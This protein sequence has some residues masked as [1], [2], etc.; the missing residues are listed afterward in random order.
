M[1]LGSLSKLIRHTTVLYSS[2]VLQCQKACMLK[3]TIVRPYRAC[4]FE[5]TG[6]TGAPVHWSTVVRPCFLSDPFPF[7]FI[8]SPTLS[9][10]PFSPLSPRRRMS[11]L[12]PTSDRH[13]H[14]RSSHFSLPS[15]FFVSVTLSHSASPTTSAFH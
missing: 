7:P 11:Q 9:K 4:N 1:L 5:K 12:P 14:R 13:G 3:Q 2:T 6:D 10:L 15:S 8:F